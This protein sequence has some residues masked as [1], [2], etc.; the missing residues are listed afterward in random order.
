[1]PRSWTATLNWLSSG[2]QKAKEIPN[3]QQLKN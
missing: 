1:L 2:L 3:H